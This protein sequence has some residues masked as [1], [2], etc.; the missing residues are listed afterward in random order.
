MTT[1]TLNIQLDDMVLE[2]AVNGQ[3]NTIQIAYLSLGTLSN[4]R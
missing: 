2:T 3:A 1:L 4:S